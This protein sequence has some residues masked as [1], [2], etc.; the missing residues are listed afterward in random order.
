MSEKANAPESDEAI[1]LNI[2]CDPIGEVWRVYVRH[3]WLPRSLHQCFDKNGEAYPVVLDLEDLDRRMASAGFEFEK[4]VARTGG[5]ELLARGRAAAMLAAW[6]SSAFAS[7]VRQA[8][9][10]VT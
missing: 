7:G 1:L 5:V 9:R 4:R 3:T 6:L 10:D 2:F 8:T